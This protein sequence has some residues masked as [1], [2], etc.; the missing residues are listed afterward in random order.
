[1]FKIFQDSIRYI[2]VKI[3]EDDKNKIVRNK[4]KRYWKLFKGDIV[5]MGKN[6]HVVSEYNSPADQIYTSKY[7]K[8]KYDIYKIE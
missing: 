3:S 2:T 4:S 6:L 8:K 7:F 5:R 1:M